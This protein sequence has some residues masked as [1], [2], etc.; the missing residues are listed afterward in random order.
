MLESIGDEGAPVGSALLEGAD[1]TVG[2]GVMV[3]ALV[4]SEVV[5]VLGP[6]EGTNEGIS[7]GIEEEE[8]GNVGTA[9]EDEGLDP[10]YEKDMDME[11]D[12]T[13]TSLSRTS[14]SLG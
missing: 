12:M 3:G 13:S 11:K 10:S 5:V 8:G 2:A 4:G 9:V 6:L 7:D 1:D 14:S